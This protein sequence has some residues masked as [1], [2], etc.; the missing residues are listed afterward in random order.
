ML[1]HPTRAG[2]GGLPCS[3]ESDA[4]GVNNKIDESDAEG[5]KNKI[6]MII[7]IQRNSYVNIE[8]RQQNI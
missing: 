4:E 2:V 7:K 6:D 5:V 1:H 3:Q 8:F